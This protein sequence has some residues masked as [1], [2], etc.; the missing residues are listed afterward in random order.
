MIEFTHVFIMY[1]NNILIQFYIT[2]FGITIFSIN[3][4]AYKKIFIY[5]NEVLYNSNT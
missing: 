2:I 4:L 3:T 1:K 5:I